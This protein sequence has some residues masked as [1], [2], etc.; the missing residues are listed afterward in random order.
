MPWKRALTALAWLAVTVV[1]ALGLLWVFQ[2]NLI[3]L[4]AQPVPDA[5]ARLEQVTLETEDG[6]RLDGWLVPADDPRGVVVVFNGN[7]GNRS[8]RVP[9]GEALAREGLTVLLT[10]YRGYGGNPG[11]PTEEGLAA[12]A[13]AALDF[14]R[15]RFASTPLVYFGESLGAGVA[16]GLATEEPPA[17][18]VLRSPFTSL[19][20]IAAVH[21]R[22]LPA[23]VLLRD[24]YPNLDRISTIETPVMVIAGDDDRIVPAHQSRRVYEEAREPKSLVVIDGVGHNDR[25]L[26]D[27]EEMIRAIVEFLDGLDTMRR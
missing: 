14:A 1:V 17:A 5:P 22:W 9:L 23:S 3:Y 18:L 19:P 12:D 4:P 15:E 24:R 11:S 20:D 16:I 26:L 8:N 21:Y 2:R 7:A 25:G 13:R 6:L 10:D 27:G